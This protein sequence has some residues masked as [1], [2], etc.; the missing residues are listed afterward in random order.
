[1]LSYDPRGMTWDTWCKL[2]CEL[3]ASQ[4]LTPVPESAWPSWVSSFL[5]YGN[6]AQ[7]GVPSA[8]GFRTWREWAEQLMGLADFG[9]TMR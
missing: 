6:V 3:V 1:M 8:H 9:R 4:Q 2:M 7:Q 5:T